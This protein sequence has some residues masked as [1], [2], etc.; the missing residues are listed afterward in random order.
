MNSD[1]TTREQ[2]LPE[3]ERLTAER[4]EA[5]RLSQEYYFDISQMA[6]SYLWHKHWAVDAENYDWLE[7]IDVPGYGAPI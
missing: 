1:V 5:R 6:G 2:C 3:I 4:D 7:K